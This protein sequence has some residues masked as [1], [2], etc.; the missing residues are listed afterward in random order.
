MSFS[1]KICLSR[2]WWTPEEILEPTRDVMARV[3]GRRAIPLDPASA[4]TNPTRAERFYVAPWRGDLRV[5]RVPE[6]ALLDLQRGDPFARALLMAER[7]DPVA[8]CDGL[9]MPW[10]ADA[11]FLNPPFG[12]LLRPFLQRVADNARRGLPI[13]M[14][15][16]NNRVEQEYWQRAALC[17]APGSICYVRKRVPFLRPDGTK[18]KG[19]P[20]ATLMVAINIPHKVFGDVFK[21]IGTCVPL[22]GVIPFHTIPEV[23]D[24]RGIILAQSVNQTIANPF[25]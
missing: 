7:W 24:P 6:G 11:V 18:A 1:D 3:I 16:P 17:A 5:P 20:H 12:C 22:E 19:N 10:N 13:I 14:L 23:S 25:I 2:E 9:W 15:L 8:Y 4:V 21:A